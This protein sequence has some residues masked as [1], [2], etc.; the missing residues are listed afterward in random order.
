MC[1]ETNAREGEGGGERGGFKKKKAMGRESID[2]K[3]E[4][5]VGW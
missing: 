1:L 4:E 3:K 5:N 2:E